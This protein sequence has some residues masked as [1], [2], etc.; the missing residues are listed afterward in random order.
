MVTI[1]V[2]AKSWLYPEERI[3]RRECVEEFIQQSLLPITA[4]V[5]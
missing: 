2:N 4:H 5:Q 3:T 1:Q